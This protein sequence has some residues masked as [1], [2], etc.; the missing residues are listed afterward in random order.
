FPDVPEYAVGLGG[1]CCN[2]GHLERDQGRPEPALPLYDQAV[3]VLG[4]VLARDP[5]QAVAR[6]YLRNAHWGRAV[7]LDRSSRH[8]EAVADW[9]RVLELE[10]GPNRTVFR[11]QR[12]L[13]LARAGEPARAAPEIEA[14]AGRK[15]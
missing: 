4:T 6:E 9:D 7:V 8:A 3:K 15:D 14:L 2:L 10:N 5:R 1:S 11:M 13:S 12:A